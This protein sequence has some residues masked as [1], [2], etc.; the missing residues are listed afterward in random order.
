MIPSSSPIITAPIRQHSKCRCHLRRWRNS[1]AIVPTSRDAAHRVINANAP[2][3]PGQQSEDQIETPLFSLSGK[4]RLQQVSIVSQR[5]TVINW[6]TEEANHSGDKSIA[7]KRWLSSQNS[8]AAYK[9]PIF[10]RRHVGGKLE[11]HSYSLW[12]AMEGL[13]ASQVFLIGLGALERIFAW[14]RVMEEDVNLHPGSN[15]Y[16]F[17]CWKNLGVWAKQMSSSVLPC[18]LH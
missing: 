12:T 4:R 17:S 6:M 2:V 7:S 18:T 5:Y 14:K 9:K 10:K 11:I 16:T 3:A 15:G 13:S 8:S 1:I